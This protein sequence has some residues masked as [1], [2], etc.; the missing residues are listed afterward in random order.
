MM[1]EIVGTRE[2]RGHLKNTWWVV[3]LRECSEL[4]SAY[5]RNSRYVV[6]L[7]VLFEILLRLNVWTCNLNAGDWYHKL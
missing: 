4:Q 7:R 3:T 1:I 2:R 5:N 6:M